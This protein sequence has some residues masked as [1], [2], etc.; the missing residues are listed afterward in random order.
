MRI[1]KESQIE[2]RFSNGWW[3]DGRMDSIWMLRCKWVSGRVSECRAIKEKA[4]EVEWHKRDRD[5]GWRTHAL[6]IL[7]DSVSPPFSNKKRSAT[8]ICISMVSPSPS[9][10][11]CQTGSLCRVNFVA[12]HLTS[13]AY[14]AF[15]GAYFTFVFISDEHE[16]IICNVFCTQCNRCITHSRPATTYT[17]V[18]IG[19][20]LCLIFS[21]W[22]DC[23]ITW[24]R[25]LHCSLTHS[26]TDSLF[27]RF[28]V[29]IG[30]RLD[31]CGP[32]STTWKRFIYSSLSSNMICEGEVRL[33][34][35]P[36]NNICLDNNN[37]INNNIQM[38]TTYIYIHAPSNRMTPP[39]FVTFWLTPP[40]AALDWKVTDCLCG[41]SIRSR[42]SHWTT[43]RRLRT[44]G[45]LTSSSETLSLAF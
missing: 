39:S 27:I 18:P 9:Y 31:L 30:F 8:N 7:R 28:S 42:P 15:Y 26:L 6:N 38:H 34:S 19:Q 2:M 4:G 32:P 22:L 24:R 36:A 1:E 5:Q 33:P 45:H 35:L 20:V 16:W 14:T 40:G 41:R 25:Y 43:R 11:P 17:C 10:T 21:F 37:A 13:P 12:R 23:V 29:T 3:I 44:R